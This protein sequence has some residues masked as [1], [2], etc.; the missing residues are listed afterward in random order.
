MIDTF[1]EDWNRMT[2][3]YMMAWE[4]RGAMEKGI[5]DVMRKEAREEIRTE[6]E[7]KKRGNL[8]QRTS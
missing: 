1:D 2:D 6:R 4:A 5:D 3:R 7:R 8:T